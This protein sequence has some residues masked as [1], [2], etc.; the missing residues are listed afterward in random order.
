MITVFS[1][2]T[3]LTGWEDFVGDGSDREEVGRAAL[4]AC[5]QLAEHWQV[6]P[7]AR[8]ADKQITGF[9]ADASW[10]NFET[11]GNYDFGRNIT[12]G[13]GPLAL[14]PRDLSQLAGQVTPFS[15]TSLWS[16]AFV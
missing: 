3:L 2:E 7:T 10:R 11:C 15:A 16:T 5:A 4:P 6:M 8:R 9:T 13:N 1:G 14:E 12:S